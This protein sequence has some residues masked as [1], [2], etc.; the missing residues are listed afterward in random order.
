MLPYVGHNKN[1]H[2]RT[3]PPPKFL[4]NVFAPGFI[5]DQMVTYCFCRRV[6]AH[7]KIQMRFQN[8]VLFNSCKQSYTRL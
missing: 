2:I 4:P 1:C 8:V 6:T 5:R 3:P 7:N